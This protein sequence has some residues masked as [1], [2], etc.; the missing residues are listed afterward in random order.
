MRGAGDDGGDGALPRCAAT[1][2]PNAIAASVRTARFDAL[3][4]LSMRSL[5][6]KTRRLRATQLL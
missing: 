4:K 1:P 6:Q 5:C 3:L 2:T